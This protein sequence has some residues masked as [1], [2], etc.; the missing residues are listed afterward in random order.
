MPASPTSLPIIF[1]LNLA[2]TISLLVVG[3]SHIATNSSHSFTG[4]ASGFFA[5]FF[6]AH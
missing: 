3:T 1:A 2:M 5:A 6:N 4:Y